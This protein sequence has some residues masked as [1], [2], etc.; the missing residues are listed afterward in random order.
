MP[1][2]STR[3]AARS[4][5][6]LPLRQSQAQSVALAVDHPLAAERFKTNGVD[7]FVERLGEL[8]NATRE[9]QLG[10]RG[11]LTGS[12]ARIEYDTHGRA[13]R[14]F[15]LL[16]RAESA[17]SIVIDPRLAF[18]R[19]VMVGTSVP[20]ADVRARFDAG[21]SVSDLALDFDVAA[22]RIED[23]LRATRQAA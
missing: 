10:L 15:P 3:S 7:L 18:G 4:A 9:G 21:D 5:T 6:F 12:L 17:R 16:R 22:E 20:A 2:R 23:A 13:V 19:P 1:S 8:I 14:L 11:V